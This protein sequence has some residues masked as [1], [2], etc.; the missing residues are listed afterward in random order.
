MSHTKTN[1]GNGLGRCWCGKDETTGGHAHTPAERSVRQ[2]W[3]CPK[4]GAVYAPWVIE[5]KKHKR[6]TGF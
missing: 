5:C 6:L 1:F 3:E 4:C 2:G